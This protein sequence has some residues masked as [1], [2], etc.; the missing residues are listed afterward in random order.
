MTERD[1]A[2]AAGRPDP[3]RDR[4][5]ADAVLIGGEELDRRVGVPRGFLGDDPRELF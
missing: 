1:R 4:L 5:Q 3:A 2:L